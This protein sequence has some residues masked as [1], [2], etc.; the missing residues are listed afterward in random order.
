MCTIPQFKMLDQLNT[1]QQGRILKPVLAKLSALQKQKDL[2]QHKC[3]LMRDQLNK[4]SSIHSKILHSKKKKNE[5]SLHVIMEQHPEYY[6][7]ET[8]SRQGGECMKA[9][10]CLRK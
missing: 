4:L 8:Q 7:G 1:Q 6:V 9:T 10:F 2:E 3:A 5:R